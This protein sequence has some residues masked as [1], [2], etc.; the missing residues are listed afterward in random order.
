[1]YGGQV[2]YLVLTK[3]YTQLLLGGTRDGFRII[4]SEMLRQNEREHASESPCEWTENK[5]KRVVQQENG[6]DTIALP[7]C[8]YCSANL[9]FAIN[10]RRY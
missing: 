4:Q 10:W 9:P 8:Y 2:M 6:L 1:M 3:L 5:R 7:C